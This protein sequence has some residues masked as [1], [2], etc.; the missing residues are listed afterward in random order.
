MLFWVHES[1]LFPDLVSDAQPTFGRAIIQDV[2]FIVDGAMI[3]ALYRFW[4]AL[5]SYIR[6]EIS[7]HWSDS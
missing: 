5:I 7:L 6:I 2:Y 1:V 3:S 4:L